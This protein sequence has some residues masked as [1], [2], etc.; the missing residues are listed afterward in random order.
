MLEGSAKLRWCGKIP[1]S[2]PVRNTT[3]NSSPLA[4]CRVMRVI[5]PRDLASSTSAAIC[6]ALAAPSPAVSG[7][8]G[9]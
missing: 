3:G 2:M 1:C 5:T 8:E 7:R 4:V 6:W 9:I